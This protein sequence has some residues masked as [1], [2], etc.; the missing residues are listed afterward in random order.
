M[1]L[2]DYKLNVWK[3]RRR[4]KSNGGCALIQDWLEFQMNATE[5]IYSQLSGECTDA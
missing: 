3:K 1:K 5:N 2:V 4:T